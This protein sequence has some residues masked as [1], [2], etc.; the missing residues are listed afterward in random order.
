M[1]IPDQFKDYNCR[2]YFNS[3]KFA[4]GFYDERAGFW[5]VYADTNIR[6]HP[7]LEFLAVGGPGC[8]GLEWGYR[9][10]HPGLWVFYPIEQRFELLAPT[11]AE[12]FDGWYSGRIKV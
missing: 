3:Q 5:T 2:E 6:E 8:D 1:K 9:K 7:E 10:G 12:L 11:L 4:R